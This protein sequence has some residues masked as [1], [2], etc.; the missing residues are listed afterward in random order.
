MSIAEHP[1]MGTI[2]ICDFDTSFK[3]P[4][5]IKR[6]P[7]IVISPKIA[8]RKGL[9]TVVALST[10][11]PRPVLHYHKE[12]SLRLPPPWASGSMWIKGDMIYAV[13]FHRLDF[14]ILGKDANGKRKYM[15]EPLTEEQI[16]LTRICVLKSMGLSLLTKHL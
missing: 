8:M 4:E 6:R 13:G 9:C 3:E 5:M 2:L 12:I 7:V 1:C 14:V 16:K 15:R 11:S 10:T